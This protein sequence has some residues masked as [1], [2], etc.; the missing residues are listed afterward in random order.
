VGIREDEN[1]ITHEE[2]LEAAKQVEPNFAALF[3]A[4]IAQL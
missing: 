3:A 2:V 4:L 1:V